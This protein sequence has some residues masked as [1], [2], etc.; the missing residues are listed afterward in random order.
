M[1]SIGEL[2]EQIR[3]DREEIRGLQMVLSELSTKK[4]NLSGVRMTLAE[5]QTSVSEYD[6]LK[7]GTWEGVLAFE[8][9]LM[10]KQCG[11][12]I[13]NDVGT[14]AQIIAEVSAAIENVRE[15]IS[16]LHQDIA[17][18]EAEIARLEEGE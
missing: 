17:E 15:Q 14:V 4:A 6:L 11:E 12:S 7:N 1:S 10:Q 9:T 13:E 3:R 5:H 2:R 8:A 16:A 18:C